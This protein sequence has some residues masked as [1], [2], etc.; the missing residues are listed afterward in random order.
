MTR[1]SRRTTRRSAYRKARTASS[2]YFPED[3]T[4]KAV[5]WLHAVR[6]HNQN[7][8]WMLYYSTGCSHAPHHVGKEW[9]DK[10]KGKF[11]QGWDKYREETLARQRKLGIVPP[12]TELSARPDL[13]PA[14]D[15]LSDPQKKLYARQMEVFAG[16][17]RS[18]RAAEAKRVFSSRSRTKAHFRHQQPDPARS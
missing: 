12:D 1:S 2:N 6:A 15:S 8:P 5:G 18:T 17:M 13:F 11:D 9:A 3:I 14:W 16:M 4:D 10:Y 7:K